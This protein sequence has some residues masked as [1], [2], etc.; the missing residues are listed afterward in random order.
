MLEKA[1]QAFAHLD[2]VASL[3]RRCVSLE[4]AFLDLRRQVNQITERQIVTP[5]QEHA[6]T[7]MKFAPPEVKQEA[8]QAILSDIPQRRGF[9]QTLFGKS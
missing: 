7:T 8:Q 4:E 5:V 9:F 6:P 3:T 2:E 1:A